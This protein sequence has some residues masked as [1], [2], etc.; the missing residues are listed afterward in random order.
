MSQVLSIGPF[1]VL[2]EE[3]F[4]R[5]LRIGN[6][7]VLRMVYFALR[8]ENWGTFPLDLH[9]ER[10]IHSQT[11]YE[12]QYRATHSVGGQVV[13]EW[14]VLISLTD[15][16]QVIFHIQ[17]RVLQTLS[18]N[19]AGCCVLHPIDTSIGKA[20][21]I[22]HPDGTIETGFFPIDIDPDIVFGQI[23]G[24]K[25]QI[26][27]GCEGE[28]HFEGDIFE[29]E[30]QRNWTDASF[31]TYCTPLS[32]PFPRTLEAG[33]QVEQRIV[34]QVNGW[35]AIPL[36]ASAPGQVHVQIAHQK[37]L[38]FPKIG[39]GHAVGQPLPDEVSARR[40]RALGLNHLRVEINFTH[41]DWPD[42]WQAASAEGKLLGLQLKVALVF[43]SSMLNDWQA[44]KDLEMPVLHSL[45]L[46]STTRRATPDDLLALLLPLI[47]NR[48]PGV[49]VG[50]G[51]HIHFTDLNRYRFDYSQPDFISYALNPQVHAFDDRTLVE[52]LEAQ[53]YTARQALTFAA[54]KPL[55]ISPVTLRPRFN[56][57]AK[58]E[59]KPD[60]G[61]LPFEVDTRQC[62]AFAA[63]WVLGSLKYLSESGVDAITLFESHGLKGFLFAEQDIGHPSLKVQPGVF[64]VYTLMY[65]IKALNPMVVVA[66]ESSDPLQVSSWVL[67]SASGTWLLLA[68]HQATPCEVMVEHYLQA[69]DAYEIS[70]RRLG[71]G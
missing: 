56:P 36:Q 49:P 26:A 68:N 2:Y 55:H 18:V 1:S 19:R 46:F 57:E 32:L 48:F 29:M 17:G 42:T 35:E 52:N 63:A 14:E 43:S 13:F 67:K 44:F 5:Y 60:P 33:A 12:I 58:A 24:L 39:T 20:V 34:F 10:V 69:L 22:T 45:E 38:P 25:W 71:G 7:E 31:K 51:S 9:E 37:V 15:T 65:K 40:L 70:F 41:P 21:E 62:T 4:L 64:S 53:A 61:V 47:R 27:P 8:D 28:L 30:D 50:A 6:L 16:G 3:G 54:K 11:G 66:S 23:A 59:I